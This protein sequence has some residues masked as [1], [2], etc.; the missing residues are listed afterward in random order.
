MT[1]PL[2]SLDTGALSAFS[3]ADADKKWPGSVKLTQTAANFALK[4]DLPFFEYIGE[5]PERR[6][7][8]AGYMRAVTASQELSLSHPV[9]WPGLE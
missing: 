1:G 4:T 9:E 3:M 6:R 8:F 7:Q 2:F 5:D